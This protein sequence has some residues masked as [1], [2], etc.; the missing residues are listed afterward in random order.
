MKNNYKILFGLLITLAL[1]SFANNRN[2]TLTLK[3][4]YGKWRVVKIQ[5]NSDTLSNGN[6]IHKMFT[7]HIE[8]NYF[9]Y[10]KI[11]KKS[12]NLIGKEE[13]NTK[14]FEYNRKDI[15]S[16]RDTIF[17][18]MKDRIKAPGM[19]FIEVIPNEKIK[20]IT[21]TFNFTLVR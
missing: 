7:Q 11:N 6:K 8:N 18:S 16:K 1:Y 5:F 3:K 10:V 13:M 14:C 17:I 2:N 12:I 20:F 15:Y 4:F 9:N 21:S 19:T